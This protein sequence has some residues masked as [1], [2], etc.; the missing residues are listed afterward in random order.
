MT[1]TY[2]ERLSDSPYVERVWRTQSEG[3]G[4]VDSIALSHWMLVFWTQYGKIN[5]SVHAPETRT[6]TAAPIPEEADFFG[7]VFKHGTFMPHLPIDQLVNDEILL[8]E[9]TSRSFWLKGSAWEFPTYHN[10]DTFVSRLVH[11]GI[12]VREPIIDA[13]TR[14]HLSDLSS[15]SIQRRVLRTTGLTYNTIRQIE[16]ARQAAVLLREG[17]SILD[18]VFQTGYSDQPHLTRALKQLIGRTPAQLTDISKD[19]HLSVLFKT[20]A[21]WSAMLEP[22]RR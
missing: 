14:G 15:R 12:L 4:F 3:Q 9:A 5:I 22:S 21:L 20:T 19:N 8:P 1:L 17:V 16:R 7:V 18:T 10:V 11:N 2:E 6:T 13:F